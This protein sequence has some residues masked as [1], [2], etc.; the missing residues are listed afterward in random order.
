LDWADEQAAEVAWSRRDEGL[1][2]LLVVNRALRLRA[3]KPELFVRGS[4]DPLPGAG[5]R[6]AHA[7][8]LRRGGGRAGVVR[9]PARG[10]CGEVTGLIPVS[11]CRP[12][13]GQIGSRVAGIP[14]ER[15]SWRAC[16][17]ASR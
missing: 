16:C 12:A 3:E 15:C 10:P 6:G 2:Q 11:S 1:P 14:V 8:A 5:A 13:T 7:P 4:F 9:R 17:T